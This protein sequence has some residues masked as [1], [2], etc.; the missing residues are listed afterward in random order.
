[1]PLNLGLGSG[2]LR[3]LD[4]RMHRVT[5]LGAAFQ[6]PEFALLGVQ[7]VAAAMLATVRRFG[8]HGRAVF[9]LARVELGHELRALGD[10]R[11]AGRE[12]VHFGPN[13][14]HADLELR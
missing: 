14:A 1:M 10:A 12:L 13:L 11:L 8:F 2:E 4:E 3:P 5:A 7:S 6:G 9:A